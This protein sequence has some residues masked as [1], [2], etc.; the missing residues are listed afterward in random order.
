MTK[1]LDEGSWIKTKRQREGRRSSDKNVQVRVKTLKTD[2]QKKHI[3]TSSKRSK[4]PKRPSRKLHLT[5]LPDFLEKIQ[6]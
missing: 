1:F 5:T 3:S 2:V 6:N 4:W